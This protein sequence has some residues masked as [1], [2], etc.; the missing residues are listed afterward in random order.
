MTK[1]TF[2]AIYTQY[3]YP[4][5]FTGGEVQHVTSSSINIQGAAETY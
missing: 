3:Q 2:K 5:S 4:S 1:S